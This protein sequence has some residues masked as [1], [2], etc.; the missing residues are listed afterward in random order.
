MIG[1]TAVFHVVRARQDSFARDDMQMADHNLRVR[2]KVE[3]GTRRL[4]VCLIEFLQC[5]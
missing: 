4:P 1:L 3:I 2:R 5:S